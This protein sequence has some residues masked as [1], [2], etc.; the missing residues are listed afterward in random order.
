MVKITRYFLKEYAFCELGTEFVNIK[1]N[2]MLQRAD[3]IVD[4]VS[5]PGFGLHKHIN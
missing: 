5:F 2:F 4:Y 1:M 3:S